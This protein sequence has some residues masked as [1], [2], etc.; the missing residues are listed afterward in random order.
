[1]V[2]HNDVTLFT[3]YTIHVRKKCLI[4]LLRQEKGWGATRICTECRRKKWVVSSVNNILRKIDK[5]GSVERMSAHLLG[6]T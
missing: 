6:E 1:M 3:K 2:H 4:K 5:T